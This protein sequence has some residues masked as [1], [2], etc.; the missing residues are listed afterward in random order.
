MTVGK[1]DLSALKEGGIFGYPVDSG[2]GCF[3]DRAA[4]EAL[5]EEMR[6]N[7]DYYEKMLAEMD[8]TYV[9]T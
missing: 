9:H 6:A 3:M 8:K 7:P 1:Q 4:R 5:N 2:T